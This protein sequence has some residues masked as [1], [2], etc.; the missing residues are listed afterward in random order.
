M[1]AQYAHFVSATDALHLKMKNRADR[2]SLGNALVKELK[3][4]LDSPTGPSTYAVTMRLPPAPVAPYDLREDVVRGR[5]RARVRE[6]L[7]GRLRER[8]LTDLGAGA[9]FPNS[10]QRLSPIRLDI[11]VRRRIVVYRHELYS[12]HVGTNLYSRFRDVT[13][14]RFVQ[15]TELQS[16]TRMWVRR[17]LQAL[18]RLQQ[19][20]RDQPSSCDGLSIPFECLEMFIEFLVDLLKRYDMLSSDGQIVRRLRRFLG[21]RVTPLFLHELRAWLRSPHETMDAWDQHAQ[22]ARDIGALTA[23]EE[24]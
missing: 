19:A 18:I 20:S 6:R 15:D 21:A 10:S 4:N 17:E 14:P 23:V 11:P 22:Y 13:P 1:N 12:L 7:R 3:Y 9:S 24:L 5:V 8:P 16:R 2:M